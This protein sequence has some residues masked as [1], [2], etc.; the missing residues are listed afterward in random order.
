MKEID[1]MKT[2]RAYAYNMWKDAPMPMVTLLKRMEV[3]RL[4]RVSKRKR[5]K[6]N[7]LMCWCIGRAASHTR[8]FYLLPVGRKLIQYSA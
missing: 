3:S 5:L 6:F 7:M 8:E 2:S 1:P 4:H